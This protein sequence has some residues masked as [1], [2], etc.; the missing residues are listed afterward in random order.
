MSLQRFQKAKILS[1]LDGVSWRLRQWVQVL[2]DMDAAEQDEQERTEIRAKCGELDAM[3]RD[4]ADL[5]AD[6]RAF[7]PR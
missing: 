6:I 4:L 3:I 1:D 5:R 2:A 7:E